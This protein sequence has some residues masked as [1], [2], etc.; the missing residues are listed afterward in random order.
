MDEHPKNRP[1]AGDQTDTE[2]SECVENTEDEMT[3]EPTTTPTTSTR[4]RERAQQLP[5]EK[6]EYPEESP[7]RPP[8]FPLV[9]SGGGRRESL[10][11]G[12]S[13]G[14]E[15]FD[16]HYPHYVIEGNAVTTGNQSDDFKEAPDINEVTEGN[17]TDDTKEAPEKKNE[18]KNED[19]DQKS[20]DSFEDF[21]PKGK[22]IEVDEEK[23]DRFAMNF[24][25]KAQRYTDG[26]AHELAKWA[27]KRAGWG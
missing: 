1:A 27:D 15:I 25:G 2:Q 6:H 24:L 4:A 3:A 11:G 22:W 7:P 20:N 8:Q 12:K 18:M 14:E 17:D 26:S 21:F 23:F 13:L 16:Q 9:G 19:K 5:Q 10:T